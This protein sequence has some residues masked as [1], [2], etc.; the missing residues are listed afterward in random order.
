MIWHE[1]ISWIL[2]SLNILVLAYIVMSKTYLKSFFA[3]LDFLI[4]L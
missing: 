3:Q 2:N 4:N 1:I